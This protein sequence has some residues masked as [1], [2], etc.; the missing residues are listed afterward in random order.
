MHDHIIFD[1]VDSRNFSAYCFAKNN[2]YSGP[3]RVYEQLTIPGKSGSILMD[4]RRHNNIDV[5]YSFVILE[6]AAENVDGFRNFL[7]SCTGYKRLE[8]T[9]HPDEYYEAC[10]M[11]SF[12]AVLDRKRQKAKFTVT[13]SRKPQ[14]FLKMGEN[15]KRFV[16]DGSI[17][18]PT[19]FPSRPLIRIFGAGEVGIGDVSI[20][21]AD[22]G[23]SPPDHIDVDSDIMECFSWGDSYNNK[24]SFSGNDYP[25]LE[26]GRNDITLGT[27]IQSLE[28]T[29]RW[30]KM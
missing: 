30:Y 22:L 5:S 23:S 12:T 11:D 24:V 29:P 7:M 28:I 4:S 15:G 27:G 10:Y 13:F 19:L 14:R 17:F 18:N 6:K 9:I 8:D 20:T 2:V 26:P 1:K 21:I 25:M 3:G 16:A